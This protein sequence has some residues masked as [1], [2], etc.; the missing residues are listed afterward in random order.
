MKTN[1]KIIIYHSA[2]VGGAV[3]DIYTALTSLNTSGTGPQNLIN[4][5]RTFSRNPFSSMHHLLWSVV[6]GPAVGS[7]MKTKTNH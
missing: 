7:I 4:I 5:L 1:I 6:A 2:A 3:F